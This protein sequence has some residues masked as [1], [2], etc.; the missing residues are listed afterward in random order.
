M[1]KNLNYYRVQKLF[2]I[3]IF[4]IVIILGNFELLAKNESFYRYLYEKSGTYKNFERENIVENSTKNL[5][6]YFNGKNKLDVNFYSEQADFHLKDVKKLFQ[7]SRGLFIL[8]AIS[9]LFIGI[10]L[11]LKKRNQDLFFALFAASM[12]TLSSI[13]LLGFGAFSAF[14]WFFI[15]FHLLVF[16]NN[17]WLFDESDNLI[18]LFPQQFFVNFANQLAVNIVISSAIIAVIS[19]LSLRSVRRRSNS[20]QSIN[21]TI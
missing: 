19:Y 5:I 8:T 9:V 15:K 14:D 20:K 2:F 11:L 10:N 13:I 4:P 6:G 21:L 12:L 7:I 16:S 1:I 17:L 3:I 18:K